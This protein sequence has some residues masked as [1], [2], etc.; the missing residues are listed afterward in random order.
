MTDN[1]PAK[2]D[3]DEEDWMNYANAGFGETDYSL[4]DDQPAE[5]VEE[6][7]EETKLD[8]NKSPN[9]LVTHME[10]IPRAT[11]HAGPKHLVRH[12]TCDP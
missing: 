1:T 6:D 9:Q 7:D 10:E 4:W 11:S 8:L 5:T 3:E 2:K 12:G